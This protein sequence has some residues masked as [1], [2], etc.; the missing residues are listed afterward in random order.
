MINGLNSVLGIFSTGLGAGFGDLL[1][2]KET[3]KLQKAYQEFEVSYYAVITLIYSV[4]MVQIVPFVLLYT[5]GVTDADYNQPLLGFLFTVNGYLFNLKTPQ[6]MLVISAGLYKETR[7]QTITQALIAVIGGVVLG[8]TN[9]LEGIMLAMCL[10]NLYRAIDLICFIPK[11]VTMLKV[12]Q[13]VKSVGV[14]CLAMILICCVSFLLPMQNTSIFAWL[15]NSVVLVI[16]G[17]LIVITLNLAA[18]RK[19]IL[20]VGGRIKSIIKR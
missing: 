13:T 3:S 4:A 1:A 8:T 17:I 19:H 2:R 18:N 15:V 20:S 9:G 12:G 10:S 7:R 16:A 6:G 5:E 14:S 11:H